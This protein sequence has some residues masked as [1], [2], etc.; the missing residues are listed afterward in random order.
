M[1]PGKRRKLQKREFL[2]K[3]IEENK[4]KLSETEKVEEKTLVVEEPVQE[5]IVE[6]QPVVE[7]KST[8]KKKTV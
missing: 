7:T 6:E 3:L 8:K 4:K 1:N 2:L 5:S